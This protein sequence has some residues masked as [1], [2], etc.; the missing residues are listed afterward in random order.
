MKHCQNAECPFA[1]KHQRAATYGD[2]AEVCSDC[3]QPLVVGDEES[4]ATTLPVGLG[5][6]FTPPNR[7]LQVKA[8]ALS[9]TLPAVLLVFG[10]VSFLP[11]E[12]FRNEGV[13]SLIGVFYSV[14]SS[15]LAVN[16]VPFLFA[17]LVME[18]ACK[19]VPNWRPLRESE[20]GRRRLLL[21][22]LKLG[23]FFAV[24]HA[25]FKTAIH[26][27]LR[28]GS[29]VSGAEGFA[30]FAG[31]LAVTAGS[32]AVGLKV[33]R[34]FR[35]N[36]FAVIA[37]LLSALG[38]LSLVVEMG[39]AVNHGAMEPARAIIAA[40]TC[41]MVALLATR[42]FDDRPLWAGRRSSVSTTDAWGHYPIVALS[43][44]SLGLLVLSP[45]W[46]FVSMAGIPTGSLSFFSLTF[47]IVQSVTIGV[48]FVALVK[49]FWPKERVARAAAALTG[50]G[51][52]KMD[53]EVRTGMKDRLVKEGA[54]VAVI[55]LFTFVYSNTPAHPT[56]AT[57][58]FVVGLVAFI[59]DI[60]QEVAVERTFGELLYVAQLTRV[61]EASV[62]QEAWAR[63]GKAAPLH[64]RGVHY[65]SLFQF[66]SPEIFLDVFTTP[67]DVEDV[68]QQI[69]T[70]REA[71]PPKR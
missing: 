17:L 32:V 22:A 5:L 35:L 64:V 50:A 65:R 12:V 56:F 58:L 31:S 28:H 55:L 39:L 25:G 27:G 59:K 60:R 11:V 38:L 70:L 14:E 6:S 36:G 18:V 23:V 48:F 30:S 49:F 7:P 40:G 52:R 2:H 66:F 9:I 24:A 10:F 47:P 3:S 51:V 33:S 41:G 34:R 15:L 63:Q 71:N 16:V 4:E 21:G 67:E 26:I 8:W 19:L 37:V 53:G 46:T 43:C 54:L 13:F 20:E 57:Y 1:L 62:L 44:V 61:W 42:L 68:R 45:V 69:E 29:E